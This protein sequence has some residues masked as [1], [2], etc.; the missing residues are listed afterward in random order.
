MF[1]S[2]VEFSYF[3]FFFFLND[4]AP[5]EISPLPLPA[6]LPIFDALEAPPPA[7][8]ARGIAED[9]RDDD[10]LQI[11]QRPG[12]A[13]MERAEPA[14][15]ASEIAVVLGDAEIGRAHV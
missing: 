10:L 7:A 12:V 1:P 9:A 13:C 15:R 8:L 3:F 6:P 2:V 4:P 5:P 11:A 14:E